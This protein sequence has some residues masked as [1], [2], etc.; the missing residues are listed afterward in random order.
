MGTVHEL[1]RDIGRSKV[2]AARSKL[3]RM[4]PHDRQGWM[5]TELAKRLGDSEPNRNPLATIHWS[6]KLPNAT[7]EGITIEVE[8][9]ITVP[10]LLFRPPSKG[11]IPVVVGV[12]EGGKDLFLIARSN[13]IETLLQRGVGVC[14]PDVR[15]T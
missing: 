14:L 11:S 13:E 4:D 8:P 6:K 15:G 3:D 10:L 5:R 7:V 1:A 12:A 2:E 9:N